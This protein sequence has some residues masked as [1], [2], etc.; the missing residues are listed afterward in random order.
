M[1]CKVIN[2]SKSNLE[3]LTNNWLEEGKY[4]ITNLI[5]TQDD[6]YITLTI[7]Y[8]DKKEIRK[9]KLEKLNKL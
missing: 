1:K 8:L 9:K 7:F 3:R 4:E 6:S 2:A 5:Q